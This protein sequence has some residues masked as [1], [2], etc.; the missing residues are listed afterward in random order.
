MIIHIFK[1]KPTQPIELPGEESLLAEQEEILTE[2]SP[3]RRSPS[4]SKPTHHTASF[5]YKLTIFALAMEMITYLSMSLSQTP[6]QYT[7]ACMMGGLGT[8]FTPAIK[9]VAMSLYEQGPHEGMEVGRLFGA[10][11]IVE[12]LRFGFPFDCTYSLLL[13]FSKW[14]CPWTR[15]VRVNFRKDSWDVPSSK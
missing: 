7:I 12:A 13:K 14:V 9:S 8:G 3:L 6:I 1:P 4:R 5:D 11:G 10:L 2:S 15:I